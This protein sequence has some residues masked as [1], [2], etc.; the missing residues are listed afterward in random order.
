MKEVLYVIAPSENKSKLLSDMIKSACGN[1]EIIN[2]NCSKEMLDLKNKKILFAVEIEPFGYDINMLTFLK[3]LYLA[4]NDSLSMSIA[5]ILVHSYSD[6]YTKRITQDLIFLCNN[7]GC[8]FIGHPMVEACNSL[9]NYNTWQKTLDLSLNDIC[10]LMSKKLGE[11]LILDKWPIVS[12]PEIAVLYSSPHSTSNTLDLWHMVSKHLK[13]CHINEL[14]IENGQIQDCKG[15]SYKLCLHYGKQNSCF[16]G[17][18]MVNNILPAIEKADIVVWLCPNYND[19]IAA[20][21]TSVINRLTVLY[22]KISF[23]NKSI[24][25][26][27]ISGSSGSDSVA[28]QIIGALNINKG[29]RL[30][31]YSC[32]MATANDPG[33]IFKVADIENKAKLFM[34]DICEI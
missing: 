4:G 17:G 16:Y 18:F 19:S 14:Q 33:A 2:V 3:K 6:L 11:R 28:K 5:G 24:Y 23:H 32:L 12:C 15:C 27:V 7:L 25:S 31:A 21:L 9:E 1:Y 20:N 34:K 26:I 8:S 29:F 10:L 22:R 13:C 30:P